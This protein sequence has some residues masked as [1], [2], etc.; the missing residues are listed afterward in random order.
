MDQGTDKSGR[1]TLDHQKVEMAMGRSYMSETGRQMD[2][3]S[4][5]LGYR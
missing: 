2:K 1:Y 3:E 5:K 4:N